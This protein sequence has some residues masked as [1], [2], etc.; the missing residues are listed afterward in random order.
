MKLNELRKERGYSQADLAQK[1]KC[2]QP[3]I[4]RME[5]QGSM[6]IRSLKDYIEALGGELELKASFRGQVES[7]EL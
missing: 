6:N 2:K 3:V 4:S 7:I 1:L 5:H